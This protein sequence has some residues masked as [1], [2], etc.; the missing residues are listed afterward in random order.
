MINT[1]KKGQ[2]AGQIFI[3]ILAIMVI[4]AIALVGYKAINTLTTKACQAEKATFNNNMES[5]IESHNSYN[6]VETVNIK[7][8]CDYETIC[9]V[10]AL[11]DPTG[12]CDDNTII[13]NS[14]QSD[15]GA[16]QNIFVTSK[17]R[18]IPIG[19]SDLISIDP[20]TT[21]NEDQ[22]CLCIKQRNSKFYIKFK[23]TGSNTLIEKG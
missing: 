4:G 17:D 2:I 16:K 7:V 3:Y 12:K 1:R 20:K 10:D 23:G 9:F 8:P 5:M 22:N 21:I 11:V 13:Q 6:S 19:Y 18:T 14:I 15:S